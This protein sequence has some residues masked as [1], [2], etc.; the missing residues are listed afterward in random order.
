[1][2]LVASQRLVAFLDSSSDP[3]SGKMIRKIKGD[4][5]RTVDCVVPDPDA[6]PWMI[7]LGDGVVFRRVGA[8]AGVQ[9]QVSLTAA[10]GAG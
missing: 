5:G 2:D 10:R 9:G 4:D 3:P 6:T 8:N 1:M 7:D